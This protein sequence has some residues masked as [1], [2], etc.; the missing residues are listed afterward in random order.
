VSRARAVATIAVGLSIVLVS[1]A[2]A[3]SQLAGPPPTLVQYGHVRSLVRNGNAYR[4]RFDPALWL[5]GDTASRAAAQDGVVAPGEPVPNDY[6]IVDESKRQLTYTVPANARVTVV[7]LGPVSTRIAV[8]ELAALTQGRNP[9][10]RK[11]YG[12]NLGFWIRIA[13]D[14]VTRL[15]Q[16]YQP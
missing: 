6:Y 11:L 7:V 2:T 9:K 5:S 15:D 14:R 1:A 13:G 16:Q 8:S 10:H 12:S 3:F 4:L